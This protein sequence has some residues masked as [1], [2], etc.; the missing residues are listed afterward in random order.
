M[1]SPI[2]IDHFKT[3]NDDSGHD[4]GDAALVK[5]SHACQRQLRAS[6]R[7]GRFGGEEFLLVM[8]GSDTSRIAGVFARFHNALASLEIV[9]L[10]AQQKLTFSMGATAAKGARDSLNDVIKRAD[11]ALYR[12]KQLGRD[13]FEIG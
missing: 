7:L 9:E 1:F 5:F 11:E 2:D 4:A 3:I 6:D 10:P 12:A 13:R 8:P